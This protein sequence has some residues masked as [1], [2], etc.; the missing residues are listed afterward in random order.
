MNAAG[1]ACESA[2]CANATSKVDENACQA[3]HPTCH[4]HNPSNTAACLAADY[5]TSFTLNTF[6]NCPNIV[7]NSG[8]KCKAPGSAV[9][10]L[11]GACTEKNG[12]QAECIAY[13]VKHSTITYLSTGA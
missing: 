1:T 13:K 8:V 10:C 6:A 9:A 2:T 5:C 3:Y 11:E 4:F 12:N 7:T